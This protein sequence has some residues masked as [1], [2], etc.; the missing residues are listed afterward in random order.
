MRAARSP[1]SVQLTDW[2][3]PECEGSSLAPEIELHWRSS[4]NASPGL[5]I[6]KA[7]MRSGSGVRERNGR[8]RLGLILL[9]TPQILQH[10]FDCGGL[11]D[12]V[13]ASNV[14]GTIDKVKLLAVRRN[15][16]RIE[17]TLRFLLHSSNG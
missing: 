3:G 10:V 15:L 5:F 16:I 7:T 11:R 2:Y 6:V 4:G 8:L 12:G 9:Q 17:M 13:N 1:V 14:A